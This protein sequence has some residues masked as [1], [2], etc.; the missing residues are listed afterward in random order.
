MIL[1]MF[2]VFNKVSHPFIRKKGDKIKNHPIC[3]YLAACWM[4]QVDFLYRFKL[5]L[6]LITFQLRINCIS[7]HFYAMNVI[8]YLVLYLSQY[9]YY[10]QQ[11]FEIRIAL[12]HVFVNR[13][14]SVLDN[15]WKSLLH[16][17]IKQ[18]LM[19][20]NDYDNFLK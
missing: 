13:L 6:L 8:L 7:H 19:L 5:L 16:Y 3:R 10:K 2:F 14:V 1:A 12:S 9:R 17:H 4:I 11:E 18:F 15:F 20:V